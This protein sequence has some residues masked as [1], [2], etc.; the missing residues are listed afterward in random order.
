RREGRGARR[1][2]RDSKRVGGCSRRRGVAAARGTRSSSDINSRSRS[3][4]DVGVS[5]SIG[6]DPDNIG[7]R[8]RKLEP[9]RSGGILGF[10]DPG[11]RGM[12]DDDPGQSEPEP[13]PERGR[14]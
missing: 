7:D 8:K 2:R 11:R 12:G 9:G 4:C 13:E 1:V 10:G 14:V 6:G 3:R 5:V